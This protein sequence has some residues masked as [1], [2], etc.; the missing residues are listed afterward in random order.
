[1]SAQYFASAPAECLAQH[2]TMWH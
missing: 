2:W 1:M